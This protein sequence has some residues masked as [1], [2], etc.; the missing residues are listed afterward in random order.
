MI[1]KEVPKNFERCIIV[2]TCGGVED[3]LVMDGE[4]K[5]TNNPCSCSNEE[6]YYLQMSNS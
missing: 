5:D 3:I 6:L 1:F 4:G 2:Q